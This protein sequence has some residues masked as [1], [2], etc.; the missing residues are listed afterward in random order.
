MGRAYGIQLQL[1]YQNLAQLK[2]CFAEGQDSTVLANTTQ[3]FFAVN[4]S[5]AEYV[6]QRLGEQTIMVESTSNST[7]VSHQ[8]PNGTQPGSSSHSRGIS[9]NYNPT[10][11][12]LLKPEEI[13]R[14]SER[15]AITFVPGMAPI[16]T[17]L[18]R[19]YEGYI[20]SPRFAKANALAAS[21][22]LVT[23]GFFCLIGVSTFV[24][25]TNRGRIAGSHGQVRAGGGSGGQANGDARLN[26]TRL[27][28][29]QRP[30]VR[31]LRPR[32]VHP[33][34]RPIRRD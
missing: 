27:G 25:S 30:C 17:Y 14:L 21:L 8:E 18:Q 15:I 29:V 16:C 23:G 13:H 3:V 6:S 31:S 19:Y 32:T 26:G 5:S 34:A 2:Q 33:S 28:P 7:G 9:T 1:Y 12:R 24:W 20:G 11:R 22:L 10:G 4:D